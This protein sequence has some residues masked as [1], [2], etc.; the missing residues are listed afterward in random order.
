MRAFYEE[1]GGV[2]QLFI[3]FWL[4]GVSIVLAVVALGFWQAQS[5][6]DRENQRTALTAA[7]NCMRAKLI[8]PYTLRDYEARGVLPPRV[9]K[10]YASIIPKTCPKLPDGAPKR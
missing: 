10:V 8:G 9:A 4:V 5:E 7:Q 1:W 3:G 6:K 2:I